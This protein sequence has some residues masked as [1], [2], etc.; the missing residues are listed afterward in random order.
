LATTNKEV[1][2]L[3]EG[4]TSSLPSTKKRVTLPVLNANA[5]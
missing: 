5:G 3:P 4:A 1:L 2:S